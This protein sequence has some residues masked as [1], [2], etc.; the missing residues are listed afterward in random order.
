VVEGVSHSWQPD[1]LR[2]AVQLSLADTGA[3]WHLGIA[4]K[5]ELGDTTTITY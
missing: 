3:Y 5:S 4:G 1:Q 2:T